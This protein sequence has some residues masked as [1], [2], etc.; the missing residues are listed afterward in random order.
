MSVPVSDYLALITSFH[1]GKPRFTA[2]VAASV[3]PFSDVQAQLETIAPAFDLD[4]AIGAQLDTV[5]LFIGPGRTLRV[6]VR[7]IYG[8]FDDPTRGFDSAIWRGPYD[9]DTNVQSL[10]DEVFRRFLKAC[11]LLNQWDGTLQPA[12]RALDRLFPDAAQRVVLEDRSE[13]VAPRIYAAFDTPGQGFDESNWQPFY[14]SFDD[15]ERGFD[16]SVWI[17]PF[18]EDDSKRALGMAVTIVVSGKRPDPLEVA[19]LGLN[20]LPIKP[21]GA[22]LDVLVTSVDGAP[23]AAFDATNTFVAGFDQAAWGVD[24]AYFVD[25]PL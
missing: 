10:S 14:A 13:A 20:L 25:H 7:G 23:V 6:P 18:D 8:I 12:Q 1:R 11:V 4:T 5:A 17:R 3:E 22:D 16:S 24:P 21:Q 9:T 2:T 19:L 15:P